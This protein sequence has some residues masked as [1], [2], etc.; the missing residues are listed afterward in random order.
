MRRI[1]VHL[2]DFLQTL[3]EIKFCCELQ[4]HNKTITLCDDVTAKGSFYSDVATCMNEIECVGNV[5]R[6]QSTIF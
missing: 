5:D 6:K 4:R 1:K 2:S 3:C